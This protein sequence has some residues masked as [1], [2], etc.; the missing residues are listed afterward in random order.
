[1]E[2][3]LFV[4]GGDSMLLHEILKYE[5]I[6]K[7][8]GLELDQ[9]VTRY[10]FKHFGTQ[11]HFDNPRVEWWF[12]DASKSLTMLPRSYFGSFDLVIVDLSETVMSFAVTSDLDMLGALALLLNPRGILVKN[13]VYLDC[14]SSI[15]GYTMQAVVYDA[16]VVCHQVMVYGSYENDFLLHSE[17]KSADV[18]T[19]LLQHR[20]DMQSRYG[21]WHDYRKNVTQL[22]RCGAQPSAVEDDNKER[23]EE[24]ERSNSPAGVIMVVEVEDDAVVEYSSAADLL[25]ILTGSL[26]RSG[27]KPV[28]SVVSNVVADNVVMLAIVLEEGYVMVR[29]LTLQAYCAVDIHLWNAF[30]KH[31]NIRESLIASLGGNPMGKTSSAYRI[32]AGG[33][34]GIKT[35]SK[36][37]RNL[38]PPTHNDKCES[39]EPDVTVAASE[40]DGAAMKS[41]GA[42]VLGN[43]TRAL[44]NSK[45]G[46]IVVFGGAQGES[47]CE[48]LQNLAGHYQNVVAIMECP[49][50]Q[51][52]D[53]ETEFGVEIMRNCSEGVL[54]KLVEII[55][56]KNTTIE[57]IILDSTA[58]Y[59]M[60]QVVAKVFSDP[61]SRELLMKNDA[62][63]ILSLA[64]NEKG[65]WRRALLD[66]FRRDIIVKDPVFRSDILFQA[67]AKL[68]LSGLQ[69]GVT[70]SGRPDFIDTLKDAVDR[71]EATTPGLTG[72]IRTITGGTFQFQA[73]YEPEFFNP[74]DYNQTGP[75]EQWLSQEPMGFQ[76]IFQLERKDWTDMVQVGDRIEVFYEDDD[77]WDPGYVTHIHEA[78]RFD[79]NLDDGTSETR[80]SPKYLRPVNVATISSDNVVDALNFALNWILYDRDNGEESY[81]IQE[82]TDFPGEGCVVVGYWPGGSATILWDGRDHIDANLFTFNENLRQANDFKENLLARISG[83]KSVLRDQQPRGVGRIINF[84]RD[85]HTG[86]SDDD[87]ELEL[88]RWARL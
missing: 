75:L 10:S 27:L 49:D 56:V 39:D 72:D 18:E 68:L 53:P 83:W 79:V 60:G 85:L 28:S 5:T 57:A 64:N 77:F 48:S 26:I 54:Q 11:P 9:Q 45:D 55:R 24:A 25:A 74:R 44:V 4:G 13:E 23:E 41:H 7:V 62:F 61:T 52:Y 2:R 86:T 84:E 65:A 33:M 19:L 12:G 16:P 37:Q 80:V 20:E 82:F 42:S 63:T 43:L 36:D 38:G 58:P 46:T 81:Q 8:V 14:L 87:D 59:Q 29:A 66:R 3:V 47:N 51:L 30:E 88:P 21:I 50:L 34:F 32:V 76:T 35:R 70:T 67:N 73:N 22:H 71:I 40:G 17:P 6:Q 31:D 15:F 78:G 69:L 1:M